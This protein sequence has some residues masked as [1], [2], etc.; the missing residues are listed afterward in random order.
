MVTFLCHHTQHD[1]LRTFL[2]L[3]CHMGVI[4]IDRNTIAM[5]KLQVALKLNLIKQ[6]TMLGD[7]LLPFF[8][9]GG[10]GICSHNIS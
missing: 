10:G 8:F 3:I 4:C 6:C 9:K 2:F 1:F 7:K 5:D